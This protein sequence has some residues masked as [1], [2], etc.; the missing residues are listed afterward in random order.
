M[1]QAYLCCVKEVNA[2]IPCGLQTIFDDVSL[3]G[4]TISKPASERQDRHF[5]TSGT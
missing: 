1:R 3:L 5:E 2:V 4:S